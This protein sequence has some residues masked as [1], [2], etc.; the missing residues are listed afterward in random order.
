MNIKDQKSYYINEKYIII[1]KDYEIFV[2]CNILKEQM[3]FP[4]IL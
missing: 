3:K 1:I 2:F 4:T